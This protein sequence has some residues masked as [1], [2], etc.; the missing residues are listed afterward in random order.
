[1]TKKANIGNEIDTKMVQVSE[2]LGD[3]EKLL[4]K[5]QIKNKQGFPIVTK[6]MKLSIWKMRK[7]VGDWLCPDADYPVDSIGEAIA[8]YETVFDRLERVLDDASK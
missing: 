2:V 1:V 5:V 7:Q 6:Q 8:R 3:L 4:A